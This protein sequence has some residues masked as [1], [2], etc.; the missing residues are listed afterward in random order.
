ML[1]DGPATNAAS[2]F[3][4]FGTETIGGIEGRIEADNVV[5][6][7]DI[8]PQAPCSIIVTPDGGWF[9]HPAPD[10]FDDAGCGDDLCL[11]WMKT[12]QDAFGEYS[13]AI[14]VAWDLSW[15]F[16]G[17]PAV[18]VLTPRKS[19]MRMWGSPRREVAS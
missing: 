4:G 6:V 1:L 12:K 13:G 15:H 16:I 3:P 14:A 5:E 17:V 7:N 11:S 10:H 8:W 18:D 2:P 19:G 9:A